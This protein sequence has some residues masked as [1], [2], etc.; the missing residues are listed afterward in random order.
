MRLP[1]LLLT[2]TLLAMLSCRGVP[3]ARNK[4]LP[5]DNVPKSQQQLEFICDFPLPA[6]HELVRQLQTER[7]MIYS[8]L[9]LPTSEE[10]ISVH[11]YHDEATYQNV[12]ARKFPMVPNRR[13]FF[14]EQ[15]MK[16]HVYAHFSDRVAEDLRHEVAHGYL[17]ASVPA[18][19]LWIDEG[20][21]EYFEVPQGFE[22]MNRPH[23]QLLADLI[24]HNGWQPDLKKLESLRSAGEMQ[25]DHYAESWAW[26]YYMLHSTPNR[27]TVLTEY[28]MD[29]REKGRTTPLSERLAAINVQPQRTLAEYIVTL[30]AQQPT[31]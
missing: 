24:E 28:L 6:E 11:L 17:H 2:V 4:P 22:G 21:A 26:V 16:L 14:V 31:Q 10:K 9:D 1:A 29:L 5:V 27:K 23:L 20:L 30:K 8:T 7:K 3:F 18:I 15:D 12:L 25:Q 19:P 13:A